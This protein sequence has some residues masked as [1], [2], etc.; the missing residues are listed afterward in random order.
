MKS[1][2][3]FLSLLAFFS[4]SYAQTN[5]QISYGSTKLDKCNDV[6]VTPDGG[7]IIAGESRNSDGDQSITLTKTDAQGQIA[8]SAMY[9]NGVFEMPNSVL[10][11]TGGGY[12]VAGE[13]YPNSGPSELSYIFQ[14]D[15]NG[16]LQW[17]RIFDSGG[18]MAEALAAKNTN[19]GGY[20]IAGRAERTI[21]ANNIFLNMSSEMRYLYLLKIDGQGNP[22]WSKKYNTGQ[23]IR[24]TRAND[25]YSCAD[26][27]FI[28]AG[29]FQHNTSRKDLDMGLLKVDKSGKLLWAKQFGGGKMDAGTE[30]IET[31]D[32]GFILAGETESFGAGRL[33]ICVI[34]T[35]KAGGRLWSKTYGNAGFDQI[36]A[37]CELN[38]GHVAIVGKTS[39]AGNE[40]VQVLILIIDKNGGIVSSDAYGGAGMENAVSVKP[41][42]NGIIVGANT[43]SFGMGAMDMLIVKH[44]LQSKS[45][46][47]STV[48]GITSRS[49]TPKITVMTG[50]VITES[51]DETKSNNN[52][53]KGSTKVEKAKMNSKSLCK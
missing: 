33:D 7:F 50:E 34:K 17:S 39:G 45:T 2:F 53:G 23:Q 32:G 4:F 12:L 11:V 43:M 18:N 9:M 25:V 44:D 8:W 42:G 27:G 49:F 22:V 28:V 5:F 35:D 26:G 29:E 21:I 24:M 19:D 15:K 14:V 1:L 16:V 37:I 48:A 20:I 10:N 52:S 30:V 31:Q 13:R 3:P 41:L 38:N 40:N 51:V 46:C 36:G 6:N 47:N